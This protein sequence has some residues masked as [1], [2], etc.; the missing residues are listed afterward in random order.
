MLGGSSAP[1]APPEQGLVVASAPAPRPPVPAR[2]TL[3]AVPRRQGLGGAW[4]GPP[5]DSSQATA[6]N[7]FGRTKGRFA[8]GNPSVRGGGAPCVSPLTLHVF[9]H[10]P[11]FPIRPGESQ[12]LR[13][14]F[15]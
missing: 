5:R 12:G 2:A 7:F 15:G 6:A 1:F 13:F 9:R 4:S 3:E 11:L 10:L 14:H 8:E